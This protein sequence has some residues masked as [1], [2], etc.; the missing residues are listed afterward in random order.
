VSAQSS[1]LWPLLE[2]ALAQLYPGRRVRLVRMSAQPHVHR[3]FWHVE[4]HL[5]PTHEQLA[6][7]V[8]VLDREGTD[9]AAPER[10]AAVAANALP[11]PVL[12]ATS[13]DPDRLV[14]LFQV[15][16][17]TNLDDELRR[18][19]APWRVSAAAISLARFFA[20]LHSTPVHA[21]EPITTLQPASP[22]DEQRLSQLA[23]MA[24]DFDDPLRSSVERAL[25]WIDQELDHSPA[26]VPTVGC[27]RLP[28][29]YEDSGEIATAFCWEHLALRPAAVDLACLLP[30]LRFLPAEGRAHF[31]AVCLAAY[32]DVAPVAID[33]VAPRAL[34][35]LIERVLIVQS[36]RASAATT[37]RDRAPDQETVAFLDRAMR[38]ARDGLPA[39]AL[40]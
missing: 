40:L 37:S 27:L 29:L 1:P 16:Q 12:L 17:G 21:F 19:A 39:L 4:A 13:A 22:T 2:R 20:R 11:A 7:A 36:A 32:A 15:P 18:A 34:L 5:S 14:L 23:A 8:L 35:D 25:D 3:G 9:R 28:T 38:A 6:F 24:H 10:Y 33:D 26:L 30:E 31:L